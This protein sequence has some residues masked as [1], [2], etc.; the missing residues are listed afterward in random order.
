MKERMN[1][2]TNFNNKAYSQP[3][4][5]Q[6]RPQVGEQVQVK[7]HEGNAPIKGVPDWL[8]GQWVSVVQVG[9]RSGVLVQPDD[10][11]KAS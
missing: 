10:F 1:M 3:S 5:S 9:P 7:T 2:M 8:R 11:Y 6:P 4:R